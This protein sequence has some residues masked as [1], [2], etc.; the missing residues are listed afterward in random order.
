MTEFDRTERPDRVRIGALLSAIAAAVVLTGCGQ[1]TQRN[2]VDQDGRVLPD[3][4]CQSTYVGGGTGYYR[5]PHWVYGGSR[6]GGY[7]RGYSASAP[8]SGRIVSPSGSVV[9]GGFGFFGG[10]GHGF[11]GG[12]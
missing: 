9:R 11:G 7:M 12:E 3:S 4:A 1:D 2:C 8:S 6:S 5:Y 10:G